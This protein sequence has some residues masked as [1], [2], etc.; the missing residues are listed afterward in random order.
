MKATKGI[1]LSVQLSMGIAF[2]M[3]Q[4]CITA[5][6]EGKKTISGH[7]KGPFGYYPAR[8]SKAD[9]QV[10]SYKDDLMS[11][12]D[13]FDDGPIVGSQSQG[14]ST[15]TPP[16]NKV[17]TQSEIYIV[18]KGD[19]LSRLA[20]RFHTTTKELTSLNNLSNPNNLYVGQELHIPASNKARSSKS[21][22]ASVHGYPSA[23]KGQKY[24]IRKGDTLSRIA[25]AANVSIDELRSVNNIK[26]DRIFAGEI[27][28]IPKGG[29]LPSHRKS[30]APKKTLPTIKAPEA[31]APTDTTSTSSYTAPPPLAPLEPVQ[32]VVVEA[33]DSL[34]LIA[35]R[36][37][38]TKAE[39]MRLNGITDETAIR[40]GQR[41]RVPIQK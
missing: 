34:A 39:I 26:N 7:H 2:L 37:N 40:N 18:K 14:P 16:V 13:N 27:I 20:V 9:A 6:P 8:H 31:L 21:G 41:L 15:Y 19:I 1:I 30:Q 4:G 28:Y 36:N 22:S 32:E 11:S 3:T 35:K 33:G 5:K 10:L 17:A 25:V 24:E 23:E 29:K 38:T 12:T